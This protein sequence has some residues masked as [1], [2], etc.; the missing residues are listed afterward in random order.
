VPIE[1]GEHAI[2]L[3]EQSIRVPALAIDDERGVEF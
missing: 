3:A 1:Q 2:E